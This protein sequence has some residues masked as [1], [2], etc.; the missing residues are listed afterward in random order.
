MTCSEI[1]TRPFPCCATEIVVGTVVTPSA[2]PHVARLRN[3]ATDRVIR[4]D[5]S[6]DGL[7]VLTV[8]LD[9]P[10]Q[11]GHEYVL[12]LLDADGTDAV[13]ELSLCTQT[14]YAV[15]LRPVLEYTSAGEPIT[16]TTV[17]LTCQ[18]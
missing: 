18:P 7:N 4:A 2:P 12:E 17:Q 14:G 3:L 8:L 16:T 5:V 9:Q 10:L 1:T 13:H 15:R 6:L 11:C